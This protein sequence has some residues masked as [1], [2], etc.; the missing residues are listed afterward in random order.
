MD[1]ILN[2]IAPAVIAAIVASVMSISLPWVNWGV[3]KR[4]LRRQRRVDQVDAVRS[5]AQEHGADLSGLIQTPE[6]ATLRKHLP[7][8]FVERVERTSK[9]PATIVVV[10]DGRSSGA[11]N[12]RPQLFDELT[13]LEIKW[14]LI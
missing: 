10:G 11:N 9:T 5:F 6:Y 12:F 3:E 14:K 8:D 1:P 13:I 4:R 2:F 7:T